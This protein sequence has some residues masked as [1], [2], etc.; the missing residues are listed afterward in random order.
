M[1][2]IFID[3]L[4]KLLNYLKPFANNKMSDPAVP[5]PAPAAPTP[6]SKEI[7]DWFAETFQRPGFWLEHFIAPPAQGD[8]AAW[9][10]KL[11]ADLERWKNDPRNRGTKIPGVIRRLDQNTVVRDGLRF[12]EVIWLQ[13]S[14]S[15][16]RHYNIDHIEA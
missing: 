1:L 10:A 3:F 2:V 11:F 16:G 6:L 13:I 5:V 4:E 8:Q 12:S 15:Y 7:P 14:H 9:D